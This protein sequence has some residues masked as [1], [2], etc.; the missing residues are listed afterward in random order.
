MGEED[1]CVRSQLLPGHL[2]PQQPQSN[3]PTQKAHQALEPLCM[4]LPSVSVSQSLSPGQAFALAIPSSW[5]PS[6]AGLVNCV[7]WPLSL[8]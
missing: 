3:C 6:P 1:P 4:P 2:E 5:M 8:K 7:Y